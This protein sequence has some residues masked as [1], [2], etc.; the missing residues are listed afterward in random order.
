MTG[1][2]ILITGA[3]RGADNVVQRVHF[4]HQKLNNE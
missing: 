3:N 4:H 1:K 2:T